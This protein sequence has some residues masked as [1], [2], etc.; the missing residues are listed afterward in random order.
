MTYQRNN[1]F[2]FAPDTGILILDFGSQYTWL[3]ARSLREL[4]FYSQVESFDFPLE[5]I[6]KMRPAGIVLSGGPASVLLS[7]SP[8]RDLKPLLEIAPLMGVCYGL[9]LISHQWGGKVVPSSESDS[10]EISQGRTYG[11]SEI[12]WKEPLLEGVKRQ[13]VWMSHGDFVAEVPKGFSVLAETERKVPAVLSQN[14]F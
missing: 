1:H 4:G 12:N 11:R 10:Q 9:Q 2:R 13:K 14:I 5:N 8:T 7:S 6:V 3:I